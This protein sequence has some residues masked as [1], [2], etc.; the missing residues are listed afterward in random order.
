[1]RAV[2]GQDEDDR[3]IL[4][5]DEMPAAL[6]DGQVGVLAQSVS[7]GALDEVSDGQVRAGRRRASS[8]KDRSAASSISRSP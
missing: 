5:L 7:N 6:P 2:D 4:T 8:M 3:D 1:V